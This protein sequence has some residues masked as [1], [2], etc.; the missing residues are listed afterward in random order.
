MSRADSR[1]R[2]ELRALPR[3][4]R[5]RRTV[6]EILSTAGQLLDEVGMDGFNTNLLAVRAGVR[7]RSVYRYFPNKL[8]VVAAL[9]ER[10]TVEWDSWFENF[11]RIAD[12]NAD[13]QSAWAEGIRRFYAGVRALP[14]AAAVRRAMQASPELRAID[15]RDNLRLARQLA[16]AL[17][18]RGAALSP[19]R[20][21]LVARNLIESAAAVVDLALANAKGAEQRLAELASM[22]VRYLEPLL[23]AAPRLANL[24]RKESN[25]PGGKNAKKEKKK[26]DLGRTTSN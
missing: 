19:M 26:Q 11:A 21:E 1:R 8:A 9:A 25:R 7:V 15:Q 6:E 22:H 12:R 13:W 24:D 18:A 2:V 10:M 17:R 14:G 16:R 5:A 4:E 3:Q 23:A 20:A